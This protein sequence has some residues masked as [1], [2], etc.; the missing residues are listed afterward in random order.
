MT[1]VSTS[2]GIG[3]SP[4]TAGSILTTRKTVFVEF[5]LPPKIIRSENMKVKVTVHNLLDIVYKVRLIL[6]IPKGVQFE[7]SV[8][9]NTVTKTFCIGDN[10]STSHHLGLIFSTTGV[11]NISAE[12]EVF[13]SADCMKDRI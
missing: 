4:K 13:N 6:K 5:L 8:A 1:G 11:K 2:L 12:L 10:N 7:T 9:S 3:V